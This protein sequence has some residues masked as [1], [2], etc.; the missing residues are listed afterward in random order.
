MADDVEGVVKEILD[1]LIPAL[2]TLEAQSGAVLQFLEEKNIASQEQLAPYLEQA[3]NASNVRWRGTRL[4]L[5]HLFS[6]AVKAAQRKAETAPV[7]KK[8]EKNLTEAK[9]TKQEK[10]DVESGERRAQNVFGEQQDQQ[11]RRAEHKDNVQGQSQKSPEQSNVTTRE[12]P[13][14]TTQ[15]AQEH[16]QPQEGRANNDTV[17]KKA[18]TKKDAA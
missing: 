16:K 6:S 2:E 1:T 4:R 18:D 11:T 17:D 7:E 5:E 14:P 9:D 12:K 13:G 8:E 10:A 3:G 15:G